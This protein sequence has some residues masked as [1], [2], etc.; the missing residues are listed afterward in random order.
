MI[1]KDKIA[2]RHWS[3]KVGRRDPV[4]GAAPEVFGDIVYAVDDLH[5]SIANLIL[6][7]KGSVPTEP[8]KG[9]DVIGAI[10]KHP[11]IGIPWL[12]RE[13]WDALAIWEPRIVVQKV[14]VAMTEFSR[15][16]TQVFWRPVESVLDDLRVT[17]VA[18]G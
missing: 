10:D 7:P 8:E 6:T 17:E 13:I 3:L 2:Y 15:F 1:D 9:C 12:T 18:Y 5:Q 4:T 11:D 14:T 16:S